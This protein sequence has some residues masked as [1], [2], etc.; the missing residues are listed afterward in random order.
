MDSA[1][2]LQNGG[3]L[4]RIAP[5]CT[6]KRKEARKSREM[7]RERDTVSLALSLTHSLEA[8]ERERER[9]LPHDCLLFQQ[10]P[11]HSQNCIPIKLFSLWTGMN[12]PRYG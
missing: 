6:L 11:I 7:K 5:G 10:Y 2:D 1:S 9:E 12:S 4:E 8:R 3:S